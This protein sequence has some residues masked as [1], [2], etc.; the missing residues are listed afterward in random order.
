MARVD[1]GHN[2][3]AN[4][5][6]APQMSGW[7]PPPARTRAYRAG[8]QWHHLLHRA[9]FQTIRM[10][11]AH[12]LARQASLQ[13]HQPAVFHGTRC[14]STYGQWADRCAA[15]A[16][17]LLQSGLSPGD[18]VLLF[19]HNHPRYLELLWAAW[20]AGLVV[21]PVN[22][23]L[24]PAEVEW[25]I[26]DAQL[27]WGFVSADIAPR[28]Q[29]VLTSPSSRPQVCASRPKSRDPEPSAPPWVPDLPPAFAGVRPG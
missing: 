6:W 7:A 20:W 27:E 17:R 18:R 15:L 23:K 26:D 21:V 1:T 4:P 11:L 10:S 25:I 12:L 14:W 3:G 2:D 22:A 19:M 24:H 9:R 13:P 28:I 5:L 29:R 8:G 16:Q